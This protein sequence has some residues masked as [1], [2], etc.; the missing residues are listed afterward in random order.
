[1]KLNVE[2]LAAEVAA[3]MKKAIDPLKADLAAAKR[4]IAALKAQPLPKYCGVYQDGESY[5]AGNLVT[6]SGGLWFCADPTTAAPGT[7]GSWRLIVKAGRA[8]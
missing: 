3:V 1:M 8:T 5:A 7:D 2:A 6:K 4:E